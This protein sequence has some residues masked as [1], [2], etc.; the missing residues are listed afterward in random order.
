MAI[1]RFEFEHQKEINLESYTFGL[2]SRINLTFKGIVE[3]FADLPLIWNVVDDAYYVRNGTSN[4]MY[5][6]N[7]V[8]W[9]KDTAGWSSGWVNY[10]TFPN[11]VGNKLTKSIWVNADFIQETGI[12]VDASDN[13]T[14]MNDVTIN[15]DFIASWDISG[16]NVNATTIN[17]TTWNI[18]TVN[19]TT[20]N[21]TNVNTT[22]ANITN[23]TINNVTMVN[24]PSGW[25]SVWA[26]TTTVAAPYTALTTDDVILVN[27]VG[28]A[29]TV[30]LYTAVGNS[31]R[32]LT[33]KKIDSSANVVTIDG[34]AAQ[35][36]DWSTTYTLNTQYS[37]ITIVSDGANWFII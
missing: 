30:N 22:N 15:G 32:K 9:L 8:A 14:G 10:T 21:S 34:N 7:G 18:A 19:S 23:A 25:W 37:V 31:K 29:I 3:D 27:A 12:N 2:V 24:P 35:S 4:W 5:I 16:T 13:V 11:T 17:A 1:T 6:W 36:I 28:S 33:I 26:I 20:V